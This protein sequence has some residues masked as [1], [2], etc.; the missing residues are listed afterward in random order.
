MW[1]VH[2]EEYQDRLME[3]RWTLER[4]TRDGFLW[5]GLEFG[6]CERAGCSGKNSI[7]FT[8]Y[9]WMNAMIDV[10]SLISLLSM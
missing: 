9:Y 7:K 10:G 1:R 2:R 6:M 4:I 8:G 5:T 3:R